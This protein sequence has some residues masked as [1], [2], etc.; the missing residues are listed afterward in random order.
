LEEVDNLFKKNDGVMDAVIH[1]KL[2]QQ[3]I[4]KD[5]TTAKEV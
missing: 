2:E 1:A 4:E 5:E 3:H